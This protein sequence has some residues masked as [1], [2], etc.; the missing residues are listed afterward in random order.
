MLVLPLGPSDRPFGVLQILDQLDGEA[1][2]PG[3]IERGMA[4][5]ELA[6]PPST[7]TEATPSSPLRGV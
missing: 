1:F 4:F 2:G 7:P 5:A 6:S 3:E